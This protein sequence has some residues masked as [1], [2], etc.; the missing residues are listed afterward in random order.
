MKIY[1]IRHGY[2][3]MNKKYL[4]NGQI[5]EDINEEGIKEAENAIEKVKKIEFDVIY[6][7]PMIR[8]KHT[9]EI[10]NTKNVPV[11]F[12]DRLKERTLGNFDGI[13]LKEKGVTE[14]EIYNYFY[15][16]N[17]ENFEKMPDLFKRVHSLIDEIKKEKYNNVLIVAHGGVL[18]AIHYYFNKIPKNGD[19]SNFMPTNCELFEYK[20]K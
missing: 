4:Y 7:S 10:I 19:L 14:T 11:I 3:N 8:A 6:C 20:I 18:R 16:I 9:C 1:T 12:D 2:T 13:S 5:D 15:E 17:T